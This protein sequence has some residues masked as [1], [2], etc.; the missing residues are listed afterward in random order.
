MAAVV[1]TAVI[2]AILLA[3]APREGVTGEVEVDGR[4]G[5]VAEESVMTLVLLVLGM[6]WDM[7]FGDGDLPA[8][9]P[10]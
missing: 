1:T 10:C 7:A 9:H 5:I 6:T 2:V 4:R 8:P 3:S